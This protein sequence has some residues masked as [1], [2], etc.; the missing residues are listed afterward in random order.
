MREISLNK[1]R[2]PRRFLIAALATA[3]LSPNGRPE[4]IDKI[5]KLRRALLSRHKK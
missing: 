5:I 3:M 2:A 4:R 1:A